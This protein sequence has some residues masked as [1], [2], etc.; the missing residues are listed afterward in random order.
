MTVK[1]PIYLL[2]ISLCFVNAG[3]A[4]DDATQPGALEALSDASLADAL[5]PREADRDAAESEPAEGRAEDASG[6]ESDLSLPETLEPPCTGTRR[7][8]VAAHGFIA[9]GDTWMPHARRFIA[10]G[11]CRQDVHAFDWNSVSS[12]TGDSASHALDL[13]VFIDA[14]I[15]ESGSPQVDLI[16]HSAGGGVAYDY[17]S[18]AEN[19][20]K[21]ANYAH[22]GS[23]LMDGPAGP[24]GEVPT[25]NV[26]SEGDMAIDPKGDIEGATNLRQVDSDHYGVATNAET[27][28]ALFK[29]FNDGEEPER[30]EPE[31]VDT[32]RVWGRAVAFGENTPLQGELSLHAISKETGARAGEPLLSE[33]IEEGGHFGPVRL[34]ADAR[35]EFSVSGEGQRTVHY[36]AEPF[37]TDTPL[38]YLR[39]F[40]SAESL[41][42]LLLDSLPFDD[43]RAMLVVFSSSRALSYP[44][45]SLKVDGVEV[46]NAENASPEKSTI[47]LFLYDSDEDGESSYASIPLFQSFPFLAGVDIGLTLES[48]TRFSVALNGREIVVPGWPSES[49]G[50][51]VVVFE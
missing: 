7:P 1:T 51:T 35:Y 15:A 47:A 30:L 43:A 32:P 29:H 36:Y 17:L 49:E 13:G 42:G 37:W 33:A 26:W 12:F 23:M 19:A 4:A 38:F 5:S 3:C 50:A 28:E 6:D 27:F 2:C 45:D 11:Y 9:S 10:N 41:V 39:G 21:V 46:L 20:A 22:I 18:S 40:P 25:L 14:I 44:S 24:N 34:E 16:G 8:V 48:D 31:P